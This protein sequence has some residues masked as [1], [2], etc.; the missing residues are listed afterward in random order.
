MG[1]ERLDG[2]GQLER[3]CTK[4][5]EWWPADKEFFYTTGANKESGRDELHPWCKAC[6]QEWRINK[7]AAKKALALSISVKH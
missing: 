6:Y 4:C 1:K 2:D 5:D 3:Q 7:R